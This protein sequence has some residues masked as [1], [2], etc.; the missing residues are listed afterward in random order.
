[1][2]IVVSTLVTGF[3]LP[4]LYEAQLDVTRVIMTLVFCFEV[5]GENL[6][7]VMV[8]PC[9]ILLEFK[10]YQCHDFSTLRFCD[11]SGSISRLC[12]FSKTIQHDFSLFS[13][14][15]FLIFLSIFFQACSFYLVSIAT[16]AAVAWIDFRNCFVAEI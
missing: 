4:T 7:I 3:S 16:D 1:M 10:I 2:L 14:C 13:H 9:M 15:T 6:Y 5:M 8:Y 12:P 11:F